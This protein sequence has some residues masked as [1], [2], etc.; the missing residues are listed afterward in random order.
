M[1]SIWKKE[2]KIDSRE[3][4]REDI[5]ADV[6]VIGAGMAGILTAY[7]L[8][9]KGID[10]VVLEANEI[11]G[12]ETQNTTA[13]ITSQ[14]ALTYKNLIRDFGREKA[15]MYAKANEEA[16]GIYE[17]FVK[18]LGIAC[19]FERKPAYLYSMA[20]ASKIEKEV[21]AAV[22]CG[23]KAEFTRKTALPFS[24]K[25]AVKFYGQA[26]FNPLEF[27]KEIASH[28]KIYEH[29]MVEEV[30][31]PIIQTIGGKVRAGSIVVASHYPFINSPGYYF[32]RMHQERSYAIALSNV[33]QLD[34]MYRDENASGFSFRN[35]KNIMILGGGTHRTGE[36]SSG[37]KYDILRKAAKEYYPM[38]K[39]ICCWSAQDCH[40]IDSVPYIGRYSASTPD[41]Y[42]TTGFKKWG[43]TT[44][45]VSAEII[46]DMISGVKNPYEEV[47]RPQRFEVSA[48][49]AG[50]LKETG[51]S[52][53]SL[54]F[55]NL[56]I[57]D[58]RLEDIP[59]G[60]GAVIEYEDKKIGVYKEPGGQVHMVSAKCSHLGCQLEWNPDE[61]AWECPCHGS[62]FD[63]TGAL[64]NNP[65][66]EN[67]EHEQFDN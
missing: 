45:M 22:D 55:K 16:I 26:Q 38:S 4:L 34:G 64:I 30:K 54:V 52:M 21:K 60:H 15:G 42:V 35:Y 17:D 2:C 24:V 44:S 19:H 8:K 28:L 23:I 41:L 56:K 48:S 36:N 65:A 20:D 63:Y 66:L 59:A 12:G 29:T 46:S 61:L 43:M 14:H 39:E 40:T 31:G 13:K 50:L 1:E 7:L 5:T 47:F 11:A 51:H 67:I 18:E 62:R 33:P 6:A 49:M 3:P 32:A 10:T 57:P 37:G 58:A 53:K 25:G 9:R 27:L